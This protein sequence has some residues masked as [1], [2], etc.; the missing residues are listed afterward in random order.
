M[1]VAGPA[2]TALTNDV[3]PPSRRGESLALSRTAADGALCVAP[4][5]LGLLADLAGSTAAP[6]AVCSLA[7]AASVG[8]LGTRASDLPSNVKS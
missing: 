7:T 8:F 5:A 2:L 3:A 4:V 1:S 6:F